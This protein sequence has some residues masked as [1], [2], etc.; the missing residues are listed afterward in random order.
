MRTVPLV[1]VFVLAL[2]AGWVWLS[3]A[4]DLARARAAVATGSR[5][6]ETK[7][8][9]IEYAIG[10]TGTPLLLIHGAGGG[11]DQGL[12]FGRRLIAGGIQVV[13]PSRFG[14]LGTPV[15]ADAS[16][17]AQADA[18]ACL[19][20]ALGIGRIAVLGA[21][22][23]APSAMQ[24]CIRHAQRCRALLLLVPAAY[25]PAHAGQTMRVP[26]ALEWVVE[27]V[28]TSDFMLWALSQARP[29]LLVRTMLG[30]PAAV[31][32]AAS[33]AERA[34]IRGVLKAVL[35]VSQRAA[36]LAIDA[37]VTST[38]PRYELEKITAPTLL[39]SVQDDLY[40][41]WENARYTAEQLPGSRFVSYPTGG[42][43]WIGHDEEVWREVAGFITPRSP[44]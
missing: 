13:A 24:F 35:P 40:G 16:A 36:G 31:F 8:G 41:T 39:L 10:G 22:A 5:V 27:H 28:L 11:F 17:Q 7:C 3:Y 18:H 23:G 32:D 20:D 1:V 29:E 25:A 33:A 43:V 26:P 12:Y 42:H 6:V 44:R 2:G 21:S 9:P 30:T 4:E 34:E 14:Y 38:L 19:L 15:P 37:Q